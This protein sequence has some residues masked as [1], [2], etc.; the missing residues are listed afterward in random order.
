MHYADIVIRGGRICTMDERRPYA[1]VVAVKE[2]RIVHVGDDAYDMIGEETLVIEADGRSVLPGF[3]D[4]HVH[5]VGTA[6]SRFDDID[7]FG[8]RS[9]SEILGSLGR[10]RKPKGEWVR[11]RGFDDSMVREQRYPTR[12]ELDSVLPDNPVIVKRLDGHSCVLN[13]LAL[14]MVGIGPEIR[15]AELDDLGRMTGVLRAEAN[16]IARRRAEREVRREEL[17]KELLEVSHDALR[18]GV[19]T[20]HALEGSTGDPEHVKLLMNAELPIDLVLYYQTTDVREALELG[21]PRIGGCILVDGSM[22][23]HTAAFFEPYSDRTDSRGVLY[24]RDD[25]IRNFVTEAHRRGLQIA[26]HAIGDAAI[27]QLLDAYEFALKE[28]P[29]DN[30]RHRVEHAE[31]P[32]DDQIN[33]MAEL[34]VLVAVQ[35]PFLFYWDMN[36]FYVKRLGE[37]RASRIHP[38]RR[39]LDAGVKLSG[40]SDSPVTPIDPLTGIHAAVNHPVGSSSIDLKEALRLYTIDAAFFSFEEHMKGS[41]SEGKVADMIILSEDIFGVRREDIRKLKVDLVIKGGEVIK[42]TL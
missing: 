42:S 41:I 25:E 20:L 18:H 23:S 36:L 30:H 31:V 34:N 26:M 29:R 39:M 3:I 1:S 19:T 37:G 38:Y 40:G 11:V 6:E 32:S 8:M 2:G 33:R 14:Q 17:M 7:A 24:F 15:G 22:D 9:I 5:F 28:C 13:T 4:T 27:E 35:P 21:L 12:W 16:D 10:L